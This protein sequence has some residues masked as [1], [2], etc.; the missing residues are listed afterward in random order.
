M[1]ITT[2]R[3]TGTTQFVQKLESLQV[4]A[5]KPPT[6]LLSS[7]NFNQPIPKVQDFNKLNKNIKICNKIKHIK[8]CMHIKLKTIEK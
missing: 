7:S 4:I 2:R 1:Y 8:I 6:Q 3:T 5:I